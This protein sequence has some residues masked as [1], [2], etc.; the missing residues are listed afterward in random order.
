MKSTL[1]SKHDMMQVED[2]VKDVKKFFA[3]PTAK[4]LELPSLALDILSQSG[5]KKSKTLDDFSKILDVP[6][7][8]LD[9]AISVAAFFIRQFASD[10]D[11]FSDEPDDI[12]SDFKEVF[13]VPSDKQQVLPEFFRRIKEIAKKGELG[14][15]REQYAEMCLPNISGISTAVDYRVV[16]DKNY[17]ADDDIN[18]FSP[19]C[20]GTIPLAI[21]RFRL[22]NSETRQVAFQ[23]DMNTIRLLINA[24]IALE[25]QVKIAQSH[26]GL[27]EV[28]PNG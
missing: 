5:F 26:F 10:G 27:E 23:A 28:A 15:R 11:A 6:R 16:F 13:E 21:I 24:L 17:G 3:Y 4:L 19:N 1:F 7:A 2:F 9:Q 22:D 8:Q 25:K 18:T 12:A 20:L 14:L